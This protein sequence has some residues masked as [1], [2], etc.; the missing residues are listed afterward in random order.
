MYDAYMKAPKELGKAYLHICCSDT[1]VK[2]VFFCDSKI[3]NEN[4]ND[5]ALCCIDQ[6]QNYFKGLQRSFDLPLDL[7]GSNFQKK[8]WEHLCE[9]KFG[10][11]K[12]YKEIALQ[13][14][15]SNYSRAVGTANSKNPISI[16]IP[17]HRVIANDGKLSGYAGGAEIKKWLL[18]HEKNVLLNHHQNKHS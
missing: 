6:L 2:S 16:I 17:C 1:G 3:I 18:E 12:S 11:T 15:G 13:L 10:E 8:V 7:K 4:P 14:G 9:I 5:I